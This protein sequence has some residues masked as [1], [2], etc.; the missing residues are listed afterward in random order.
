MRTSNLA[1]QAIRQSE[2]GHV[3]VELLSGTAGTVEIPKYSTF[4]VRAAAPSTTV[5]IDGVLAATM[6]SGEIMIFNAGNGEGTP[7]ADAIPTVPVT[8]TGGAFLQVARNVDRG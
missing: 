6:A 8:V 4:R 7:A 2:V 3:W 5:V 1:N